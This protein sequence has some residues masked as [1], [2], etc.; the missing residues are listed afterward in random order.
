MSARHDHI[1]GRWVRHLV[2]GGSY[3]LRNC[4]LGRVPTAEHDTLTRQ[5]TRSA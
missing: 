3:R 4:D 2:N 1:S 5:L